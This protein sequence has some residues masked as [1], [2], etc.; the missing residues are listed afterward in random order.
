MDTDPHKFDPNLGIKPDIKPKERNPLASRSLHADMP[1][2]RRYA[3][4]YE[5]LDDMHKKYL[6]EY[7][8]EG[9]S[10]DYYHGAYVNAYQL[11]TMAHLANNDLS[12]TIK[13]LLYAIA[14]KI[15]GVCT[16]DAEDQ[17][18]VD[19]LLSSGWA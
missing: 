18:T 10:L 8:A 19:E 11:F 3:E 9:M 16:D 12:I 7:I 15:V 13:C 2:I 4:M 5:E 17:F 1:D 14:R 6:P